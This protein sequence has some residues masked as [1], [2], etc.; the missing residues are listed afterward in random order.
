M[1]PQDERV[2]LVKKKVDAIL[3]AQQDR[4]LRRRGEKRLYQVSMMAAILAVPR[5]VDVG[6]AGLAGMLHDIATYETGDAQHSAQRSAVRARQLLSDLGVY[7][8][9]EIA[10]V[11]EAIAVH[12]LT[13]RVD[14]PLAE[15]LKDVILLQRYLEQ[16]FEP[17]DEYIEVRLIRLADEFGLAI[18]DIEQEYALPDTEPMEEVSLAKKQEQELLRMLLMVILQEW[19]RE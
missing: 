5:H 7:S 19:T 14:S 10:V 4:A 16:P 1:F 8:A 15:L 13:D 17:E 9:D 11:S 12:D 2:L 3:R 6:L 18:P